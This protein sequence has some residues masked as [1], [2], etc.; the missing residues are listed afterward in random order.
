M[1][2]V[3]D[4]STTTVSLS[5]HVRICV[6][7]FGDPADP[8]VVLA[9][10]ASASMLW[11]DAELCRRLADAGRFVVRYDQRDTGLS[12]TYPVGE[13]GYS[14][15]DLAHDVLGIMDDLRIEKAHLLGCSMAGGLVLLLGV[16]HPQRFHSLTFMST[17][18]GDPALP[19]M[20]A[21]FPAAPDNLGDRDVQIQYVLDQVRACDGVSP[22]FDETAAR[23]LIEADVERSTDLRPALTNPF[24]IEFTA[25]RSG[26]FP[27]VQLPTLVLHG[28]LDPLFA[29]PHG[30]AIANT[31]PGARLVVLE[32]QGHDLLPHSWDT[33]VT[34]LVEHTSL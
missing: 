12:T 7:T 9:H 4:V 31:V 28:E 22:H 32:A 34:A 2:S 24:L 17:T 19:P 15:L 26:S 16:D 6:E 27:D 21:Q 8:A 11:W 14:Q 5:A 10:G 29:L 3:D 33:F 30:E 20:T 18:T 13:P 23:A 1:P 25:P